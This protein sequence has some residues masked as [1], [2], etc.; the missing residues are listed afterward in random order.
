MLDRF[1]GKKNEQVGPAGKRPMTSASVDIGEGRDPERIELYL[2]FP[3]LETQP[4]H[5]LTRS[6]CAFDPALNNALVEIDAESARFGTPTGR[7][8]WGMHA[9]DFAG[10]NRRLPGPIVE[11]CLASGHFDAKVKQAGRNHMAHMRLTYAG[12]H[13]SPLERYAAVATVAGTMAST[14]A[15]VVLNEIGRSSIAAAEIMPANI[16][17]DRLNYVRRLS[18][19]G[20]YAG[21]VELDVPG[22][23]GVWMR[24]Y[25]CHIMRLPNLAVRAPSHADGARVKKML[26]TAYDY[27]VEN[28]LK[29]DYGQTLRISENFALKLRKATIDEYHLNDP[30]GVLV[31]EEI[32]GPVWP[33]I[34][35]K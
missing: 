27:I 34:S 23:D 29:V 5:V 20:L 24:T 14:G 25:G 4:G 8:R 9:V 7:A 17:V 11:S 32:G 21:F 30:T 10:L 33:R 15:T 13:P 16:R 6:L 22:L 12:T 26:V 19:P 28:N 31:A 35:A 1:F 2:L 18:I 3:K